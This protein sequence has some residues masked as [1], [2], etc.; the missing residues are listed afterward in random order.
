[1][2]RIPA[3]LL[4]EELPNPKAISSFRD[5]VNSYD[6]DFWS[7][8]YSTYRY[9]ERTSDK[10]LD[11]RYRGILRNMKAL[12]SKERDV[13]PIQSFLSSWYWYRKEY[14]TRFELTLR[15]ITPSSAVP[16]ETRFDNQPNDAPYRPR[17]PNAGDILF[18]YTKRTYCDD[19]LRKGL[20]RIQAS[21]MY[22]DASNNSA[23][24]DQERTKES[25]LPG[26]HTR[27]TTPLGQ[28]IPVIGDVSVSVSMQD[29]Y[30]LCMSCDWDRDLFEDFD[31]D[32]CLIIRDVEGFASRLEGESGTHL[33][34]FL[35][36]HSPVEYFDPYERPENQFFDP[37]LSKDF[38]FAYQREYRFIWIPRNP[39]SLD[40][41]KY[42][43]IGN[44]EELAEI[45]N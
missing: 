11:E 22:A 44:L 45:S 33:S 34:E 9:L 24:R 30:V 38:R 25:F 1:L 23:R 31:S 21:S 32:A 4:P 16:I 17:H 26:G 20:I 7:F 12:I 37:G 39:N 43:E 19:M 41:Y 40:D 28:T 3:L 13:I 15:G 6:P 29:Y 36:H 10:A 18:R 14:Q 8:Q 35:F 42:L 5:S 27:I 2:L